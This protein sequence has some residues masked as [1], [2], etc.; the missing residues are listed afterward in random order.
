MV[1]YVKREDIISRALKGPLYCTAISISGKISK[2][3]PAAGKLKLRAP[4]NLE[5]GSVWYGPDSGPG[6]I[7]TLWYMGDILS[8]GK[9]LS[10]AWF[11][12]VAGPDLCVSW[13]DARLSKW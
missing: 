9:C 12:P 11:F 13:P 6:C 8:A 1:R 3:W 5:V 2:S 10:D 7:G 4:I